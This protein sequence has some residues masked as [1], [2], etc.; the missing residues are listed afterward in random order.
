MAHGHLLGMGGMT[1]VDPKFEKN[2]ADSKPQGQVL[3]VEWYKELTMTPDTTFELPKITEADIKDKSKF[4]FLSKLIA[5]LQ[6]SWFILQCV[7]RGEQRLALTELE[8]LTLALAS[9]NAITYAFWWHKPLGV[10]EPVRVY[11]ETEVKTEAHPLE[12]SDASPEITAYDIISKVG[13]EIQDMATDTARIIRDPCEDSGL[14]MAF[15]NLFI[16]LPMF[17]F[18]IFAYSILLPFP[19]GIVLLLKVLKTPPVTEQPSDPR[20]LIAARIDLALHKL[21]YQ[22][23]L[24]ISTV[25]QRLLKEHLEEKSAYGFFAGWLFLLPALF[26]LLL[27]T[28]IVL[29]PF[30]TLLYLVSFIFT[31]VFGIITSSTVARGATHVPSY[32]APSTKSDKY[33][34]MVVFALF[35]VIFGGLHCIGWNFQYPTPVEQRLW[36]A[37]S[38]AITAIPLVVAPIDYILEI[39]ELDKGFGKV[40]RIALDL[41]MTI[42]LFV[43]VPARLSLIAQALALLRQQPQAAFLAVDWTMYIPH[44]F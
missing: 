21:R 37:T 31:A 15:V 10:Q 25:S 17:L 11:F 7:A 42:L 1:L 18:G 22:L 13:E 34:R 28:T 30:F 5:I 6:T 35:G 39:F 20:R 4:D 43:Y 32:Y 44:I 9:L 2:K 27:A 33:S 3:T 19:L 26:L 29:L 12:A 23:M 38:L 14:C 40:V 16:G 36:R 8:L 41:V 24:Y